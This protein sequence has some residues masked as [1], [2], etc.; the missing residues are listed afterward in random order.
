M[1]SEAGTHFDPALVE[2]ILE[3]VREAEFEPAFKRSAASGA[4]GRNESTLVEL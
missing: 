3:V 4:P 1:R 2:P